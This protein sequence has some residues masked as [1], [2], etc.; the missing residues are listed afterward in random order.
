MKCKLESGEMT[1]ESDLLTIL[2]LT[3]AAYIIP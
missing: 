2:T 3:S 1:P